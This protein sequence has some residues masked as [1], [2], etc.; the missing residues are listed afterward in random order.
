[1]LLARWQESIELLRRLGIDERHRALSQVVAGKKTIV[2]PCEHV[3][4]R[5]ADAG[6]VESGGHARAPGGLGRSQAMPEM[7]RQGHSRR[8]W[9]RTPAVARPGEPL[10]KAKVRARSPRQRLEGA[11]AAL[12][13]RSGIG[14]PL[15]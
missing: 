4:D 14:G 15:V 1:M 12:G 8:M 3:D 10:V 11:A 13:W 7:T 9:N 6:D 2:H 5:V